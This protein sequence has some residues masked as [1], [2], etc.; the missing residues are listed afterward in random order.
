MRSAHLT[1]L[2]GRSIVGLALAIGMAASTLGEDWPCWRGSHHDGIARETGLKTDWSGPIPMTWDCNVGSAFSSFAIVGNRLYTGGTKEGQQTLVCLNAD[3]G[4]E[5]WSQGIEKAYPEGQGGDGPRAT[6]AVSDGRVYMLGARGLLVCCDAAD[7]RVLWS[8]PHQHI[9]QWGYSGSVLIEGDLAIISAGSTDG[10]LVAYNKNTGDEVWKAGD[11]PVGYATPYPFTFEGRRY[12]VGFVGDS[13]IIVRADNG[14]LVWS[15]PWK[16]SFNV[17]AAAPIFHDGYLFL[18]SGYRH[19]CILVKLSKDGDKLKHD[20]VW[21]GKAL[22]NKFQS[23]V[24][25]EGALYSGDEKGLQCVDFLTGRENWSLRRIEGGDALTHSTVVIADG[26]LFV[27][28]QS[29]TLYIGKA[30]TS[31][32]KPTTTADVLS[33]RCWTVSVINNGRI[34]ARNLERVVCFNLKQ[35]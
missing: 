35:D 14:Q 29:G 12:I 6:P 20:E 22:Q 31:E 24:L 11:A 28:S 32:F 7:G 15:M 10:A 5:I 34:F 17:N 26:A 27:L 23:P 21:S 2:Q 4:Q 19:G 16:T 25:Y 18:S 8:K 3:N 33:G 30:Q 13:A 1:R 9:P